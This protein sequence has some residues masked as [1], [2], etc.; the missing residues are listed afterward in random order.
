MRG[1][2][3][4]LTGFTAGLGRAAALELSSM[5]ADLVGICRNPEK[6]EA[7]AEDIRRRVQDASVEVLVA[8][9]GSQ[10]DIRGVASDFLSQN[11]PLHVL[12]NNA[13]V[14]NL[15]REVT[16][17]GLEMTFAVNHLGPFLLTSLLINRL[18]ESGSGRVV[19]TASGAYRFGGPLNFED[20]QSESG[21]RGFQVYGRSKLANILFTQEL[22]RREADHGVTA[23]CFHPGFVASDFSKN[24]GWVARMLMTLGAPLARSPLKGAKTGL[25]LSTSP[26]AGDLSG[27]YFGN[28]KPQALAS[29][30]HRPGDEE[31]LWQASLALTG[32]SP[33]DQ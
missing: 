19:T 10:S 12:W 21:Y 11:R 2:T 32:V 26:E 22:A 8:D 4:L 33:Q 1:R 18:R 7:V 15:N 5:G 27:L 16:V 28:A 25:Y 29:G 3:V 17:D 14:I 13:G 24:N 31:K 20:L 30:A 23:N 9:L 6:G